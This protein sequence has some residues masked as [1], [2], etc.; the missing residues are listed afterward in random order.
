M[1]CSYENCNFECYESNETC[2]FHYD[3][4]DWLTPARGDWKS[5]STEKI[6][7]F[8]K[9]IRRLKERINKK[10]IGFIFPKFEE[11]SIEYDTVL[12]GMHI[13]RNRKDID[14]IYFGFR[15]YHYSYNSYLLLLENSL[16]DNVT[17]LDDADFSK[18]FLKNSTQFINTTFKKNILFSWK[19]LN[20]ITFDNVQF[21][22]DIDFKN[23]KINRCKFINTTF[24]EEVTFKNVEITGDTNFKNTTFKKEANFENGSF[25]GITDFT[26]SV[27]ENDAIFTQREFKGNATFPNI[28]VKG[29]ALFDVNG[30]QGEANF[31]HSTFGEEVTFK[32]VEITG[33]TNFKNTTFKKEA[34]F[35][36]GSFEGNVDFTDSTFKGDT[37]FIKK[38]FK[39]CVIFDKIEAINI[40]FC[41]TKFI[42]ASPG[43]SKFD[44]NFSNS[45]C[46]VVDFSNANIKKNLTSKNSSFKLLKFDNCTI[47][48]MGSIEFRDIHVD[49]FIFNKYV[50]ESKTVLFDFVTVI[51]EL[52]IKDVAFDKEKFNHFNISDAKVE[53]ENSSFNNDFFNSVKW[54]TISDKRYTATRDIFRQ[55]KFYS[56]QQKNYIDADGFYS[57]EMKE[58]K[59][60]L[61]DE[62]KKIKGFDKISHFFSHAM[63]FYIHEKTSDFSQSWILPIY[64]LFLL[65]MLGV[66]YQR[67]GDIDRNVVIPYLLFIGIVL[68][69][70]SSIYKSMTNAEKLSKWLIYLC[71]ST[72]IIVIYSHVTVDFID[73]IA[74]LI[75]PSNIFKSTIQEESTGKKDIFEFGYLLYKITVLFLVYQVIIAMK[76]KVRS[77]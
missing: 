14:N 8:W 21:E 44:L 54:G 2:I 22:K 74:K 58:R 36:N 12:N 60:E 41:D 30:I 28:T 31:S 56:E 42:K 67:I 9:E 5:D 40:N 57:L 18:I 63:V 32:N 68:F 51:K 59:K 25:G 72:P 45:K 27:F 52:E 69:F 19:T 34:N 61:K 77:K 38:K 66:I 6:E 55:L 46:G 20:K 70:I 13:S 10:F 1:S 62:N 33:D 50:N 43:G 23:Y 37:L 35:E 4:K 39:G 26:E 3:K 64:W 53:I 15:E 16:F 73:D 24:G 76:K 11:D 17:F 7:Y 29:K 48:L 75:N 49:N 47:N 71:I 65:G